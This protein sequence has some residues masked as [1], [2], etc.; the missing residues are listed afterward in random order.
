MKSELN[1]TSIGI[2]FIDKYTM[3]MNINPEFY[4]YKKYKFEKMF[5]CDDDIL[6]FKNLIDIFE[7]KESEENMYCKLFFGSLANKGD[8]R[9]VEEWARIGNTNVEDIC[10]HNVIGGNKLI[11]T[12][13]MALYGKCLEDFYNSK[14]FLTIWSG[15]TNKLKRNYNAFELDQNFDNAFACIIKQNDKL[16]DTLQPY[17]K[18]I[19]SIKK[20]A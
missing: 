9:I 11:N 12:K 7:C 14:F 15:W 5:I 8:K 13:F 16:H 4:L 17:I 10:K 18:I 3:G 6:I 2:E 1:L 20:F 19:W